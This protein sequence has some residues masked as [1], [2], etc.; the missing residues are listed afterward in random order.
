NN[1]TFVDYRA[2]DANSPPQAGRP[3]GVQFPY[4]LF[5]WKLIE[6]APG[7]AADIS[8]TFPAAVTQPAQYWK[9]DSLGNWFNA[10]LSLPCVVDPSAPNILRITITDGG[11]GDLDGVANGIILD[12]GGLGVAS[13]NHLP[14]ASA[15]PDQVLE[16]T[17]S[18][19]D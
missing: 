6:L 14:I 16:C 11:P 19:P 1:G 7:A 5:E 10:C 17:S 3:A 2:L 4:G 8:I 15:G 9:V 13:A 12:P 18:N